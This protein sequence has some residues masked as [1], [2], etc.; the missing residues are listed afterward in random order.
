VAVA[1]QR[2]GDVL[3]ALEAPVNSPADEERPR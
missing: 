3:A 1:V 2:H